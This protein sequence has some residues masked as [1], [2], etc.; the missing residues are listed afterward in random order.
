MGGGDAGFDVSPRESRADGLRADPRRLRRRRH[1]RLPLLEPA[2]RGLRH[3]RVRGLRRGAVRDGASAEPSPEARPDPDSRLRGLRRRSGP[4]VPGR[5]GVS[6]E[7]GSFGRRR[8]A[9]RLRGGKSRRSR[10]ARDRNPP[11]LFSGGGRPDPSRQSG[12]R[13]ALFRIGSG[14]PRAHGR[15]LHPRVP[16]ERHARDREALPWPRGRRDPGRRV[17]PE[18]QAGSAG[19]GGGS[20]RLSGRRS[21]PASL[22]S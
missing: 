8:R 6:R 2:R 21:I 11:H 3:R 7:H 22:S 15:G 1:R 12:P 9:S 5:L 19:R 16:G 14:S 18:L 4:A 13:R 20:S 17:P 10:G